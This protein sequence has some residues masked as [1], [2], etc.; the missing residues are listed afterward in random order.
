MKT[1]VNQSKP[2]FRIALLIAAILFCPGIFAQKSFNNLGA[3]TVSD[4]FIRSSNEIMSELTSTFKTDVFIE[5]QMSLED[6]MI[7]LKKF[8]DKYDY[9]SISESKEESEYKEPKLEL[10]DWMNESDWNYLKNDNFK[11]DVLKLEKWMCCP[12]NW[13]L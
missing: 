7:D 5:E 2:S 11:E 10:D 6:W 1:T 12:R 3:R 8:A 13:I 4:N 9:N